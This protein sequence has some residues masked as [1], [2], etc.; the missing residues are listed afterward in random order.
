M[1]DH[2]HPEKA[3]PLVDYL[4]QPSFFSQEQHQEGP[5]PIPWKS[6]GC[7]KWR[8]KGQGA[9]HLPKV[10][11]PAPSVALL[12]KVALEDLRRL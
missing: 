6:K 12:A 8:K 11:C 7:L 1:L 4:F 3:R 5:G 10:R 2:F 9:L